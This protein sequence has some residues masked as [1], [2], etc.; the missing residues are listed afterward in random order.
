MI[1]AAARFG[2][3]FR[4]S[5]FEFLDRPTRDIPALLA[6]LEQADRMTRPKEA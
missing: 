1:A 4:C 5:P 3:I 6:L 2:L